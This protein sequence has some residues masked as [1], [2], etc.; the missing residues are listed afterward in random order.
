MTNCLICDRDAGPRYGC[1]GCVSKM[2]GYLRELEDHVAIILSMRGSI[3]SKPHGS[4][5]VSFGSKPPVSLTSL[6]LLDTR[7]TTADHV[8]R[9]SPAFDPVGADEHDHVRSLPSAI[10]DTAVWIRGERD[11][12][13]PKSWT[14]VSE[15]R[16]LATVLDWCAQQQWVN[17][18]HDDLRDLHVTA[19]ALAK[20]K[21]P[22][23]LGHCLVAT[24]S[25][26]VFPATVRDAQGR[27][28]GGRCD[29]CKDTY[30]G[31]RLA[32]LGAQEAG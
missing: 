22:G 23:P 9:N 20:D 29:T 3:G 18:L 1:T 12:S 6:A 4:V 15:L 25:G 11:E 7:S 13:D 16:Y 31:S 32:Y 28:D 10:H 24:C 5:G 30:T 2:R 17:E 26:T 27:H 14:L 8:E 21:P 19:R